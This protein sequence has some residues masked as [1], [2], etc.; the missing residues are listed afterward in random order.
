MTISAE[1]VELMESEGQ[2]SGGEVT[3]DTEG[4]DGWIQQAQNAG[5]RTDLDVSFNEVK[6]SDGSL[7]YILQA[8]GQGLDTLNE[9]MFQSQASI[10]EA[11]IDGQRRI[12][13]R[14]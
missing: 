14:P 2:T 9:V 12:T 13:I 1:F 11:V 10:E 4:L 8:S 7:S 6:N 5:A 3:T